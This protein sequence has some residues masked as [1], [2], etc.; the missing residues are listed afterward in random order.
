MSTG[1]VPKLF[2]SALIHPV[3]KGGGKDPR[4]PGSYRPV[5]NLPALSKILETVVRD[6]LLDWLELHKILPDSQWGFRPGRSVGKTLTCSQ[7]DWVAAKNQGD[8]VAIIAYDLS[9][10]FDTIAVGPLTRKLKAAGLSGTPLK[11][12]ECYMT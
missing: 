2:K 10:A 3:Y 6:S 11:W 5:A 7:A 4:L 1:E 8:A 9:A 12:I